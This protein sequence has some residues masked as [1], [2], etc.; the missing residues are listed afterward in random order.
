MKKIIIP[1]LILLVIATCLYPAPW[2]A[3]RMGQPME[4]LQYKGLTFYQFMQ[5]RKM[6]FD[7]L[8]SKYQASH[9]DVEVKFGMC[10]NTE[11]GGLVILQVPMAGYYTLAGIYPGLQSVLNSHDK[12]IVPAKATWRTFLPSW[13]TTTEKIMWVTVEAAPHTSVAYCRLQPNVPSPE[14][15]RAR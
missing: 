11:V 9:P 8:A 4:L 7:D 10:Y 2:F 14:E 5:W 13:W 1:I 15:F 12:K 6:A 3:W